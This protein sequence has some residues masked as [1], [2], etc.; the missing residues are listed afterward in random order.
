MAL[1]SSSGNRNSDGDVPTKQPVQGS[2]A[3]YHWKS[4]SS[5]K[6]GDVISVFPNRLGFCQLE[7]FPD[8]QLHRNS[9]NKPVAAMSASGAYLAATWFFSFP[10][11]RFHSWPKVVVELLQKSL[12]SIEHT[13]CCCFSHNARFARESDATSCV[14]LSHANHHKP[15]PVQLP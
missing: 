5:Q 13:H 2:A 9:L 7:L 11:Q 12:S 8:S 4:R 10:I 14:Q 3:P 1:T 15:L 6:F